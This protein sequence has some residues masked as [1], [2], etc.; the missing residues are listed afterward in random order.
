[1]KKYI[2]RHKITADF[3]AEAIVNEDISII[4][5]SKFLTPNDDTKNDKWFVYGA[6]TNHFKLIDIKIFNR[7]G[8]IL[9]TIN[10]DN[11]SLGWN[12]KYNGKPMPSGEYWFQA[13]LI[14]LNDKKIEKKGHFALIR[15]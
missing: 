5:Y 12:G 8:K 1:M 3:I 14:D 6:N 9:Y 7:F 13:K 4:G 2:I 15:R 10:N 11:A